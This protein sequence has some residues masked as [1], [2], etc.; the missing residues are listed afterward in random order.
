M[1]PTGSGD[2]TP[3]DTDGDSWNSFSAVR[4]TFSPSPKV[5]ALS[6]AKATPRLFITATSQVTNHL[7][8]TLFIL[9][10]SSARSG[11]ST[12]QNTSATSAGLGFGLGRRAWVE[13]RVVLVALAGGAMSVGE[14]AVG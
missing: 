4:Y 14:V 1:M 7:H 10:C 13:W 6:A 5:T 3:T 9:I 11:L 8:G 12:E 2:A